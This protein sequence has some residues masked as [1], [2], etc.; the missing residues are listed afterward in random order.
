L[1]TIQGDFIERKVFSPP[2]LYIGA[3]DAVAKDLIRLIAEPTAAKSYN[4]LLL[5]LAW[6]GNER[7]VRQFEAWRG[8]PPA[9]QSELYL[10]PWEYS[11]E[12]GWEL[13]SEG[14]R[15]NLYLPTAYE[16]VPLGD[17]ERA[18]DSSANLKLHE[19]QEGRCGWCGRQLVS[20]LS[21]DL[22]DQQFSFVV[23]SG[24]LLRIALCPWCSTY[25][26]LITD[27]DLR[28]T[29]E[30]QRQAQVVCDSE[31]CVRIRPT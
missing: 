2:W 3:E 21:L 20:L 6:I 10:A 11:R 17:S 23:P 15:R 25:T 7:I 5:C 4:R 14:M 9:W 30:K 28:A 16:L 1:A 8:N 18:K 13:T 24:S 26:T 19:P 31:I 12:A 27:I 22:R 29:C